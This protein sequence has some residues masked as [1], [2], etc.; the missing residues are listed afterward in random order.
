LQFGRLLADAGLHFIHQRRLPFARRLLNQLKKLD[1][2]HTDEASYPDWLNPA[3]AARLG[4]RDRWE[5]WLRRTAS[6]HPIRPRAYASLKLAQWRYIFENSDPGITRFPVEVR[7]PYMDLRMLRY[8]LAVPPIPWCANKHLIRHAM[9]GILPEPVR[10]RPKTCLA[11]DPVSEHLKR[12]PEWW[13]AQPAFMPAMAEYVEKN[14]LLRSV[15][16]GYVDLSTNWINLRPFALN[17]WLK[18]LRGQH[19]I[20]EEKYHEIRVSAV[21]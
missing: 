10:R 8:L 6:D 1:T 13:R 18:D 16:G 11:G 14:A 3:F 2:G 17:Y 9:R 5:Q 4:L 20:E 21:S 15:D 12:I 7:H 19:K